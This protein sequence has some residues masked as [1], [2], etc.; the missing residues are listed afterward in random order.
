M[1]GLMRAFVA[2]DLPARVA[3]Q[4]A[5]LQPALPVGQPVRAAN[6]HLTLA[7]LGEQPEELI[8]EAHHGLD[9][10]SAPGFEI[11]LS[12]LDTFGG[13]DPKVLYVG[14]ERNGPLGH[15]RDLVRNAMRGAGIRLN[16]ERFRPHVTLARLRRGMTPHELERLRRFLSDHAHFRPEPFTVSSFALYRSTLRPD[17]AIHEELARYDLS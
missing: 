1:A 14:V 5:A 13:N 16:R 4:I 8:V 11:E 3:E 9:R 12:G 10:I 15:L 7:F 2:I 17:G 6:F